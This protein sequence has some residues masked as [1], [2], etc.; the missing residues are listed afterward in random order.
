MTPTFY[1]DS[2]FARI[3]PEH[4][5]TLYNSDLPLNSQIAI[6]A[7]KETIDIKNL[8]LNTTFF[9]YTEIFKQTYFKFDYELFQ[10]IFN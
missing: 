6:N 4:L 5:Q 8:T 10:T 2:L 9:I 1:K 7:L 3:K